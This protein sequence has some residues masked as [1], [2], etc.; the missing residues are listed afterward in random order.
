MSP[1][2]ITNPGC[3]AIR[4]RCWAIQASRRSA[5]DS[6]FLPTSRRQSQRIVEPL[7]SALLPSRDRPAVRGSGESV[8]LGGVDV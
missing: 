3:V 5:F 2:W 8:R 4:L 6:Q 1:F 7:S